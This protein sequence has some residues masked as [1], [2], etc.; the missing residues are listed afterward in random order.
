MDIEKEV[1]LC[2]KCGSP[3][4]YIEERKLEITFITMQF[5]TQKQR[6]KERKG[7]AT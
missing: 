4:S 7:I 1:T 2:P 5:I 3:Y 6:A